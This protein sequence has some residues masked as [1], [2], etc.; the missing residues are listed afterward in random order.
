[1]ENSHPA[2]F[3]RELSA[4]LD[5]E[6]ERRQRLGKSYNG[7]GIFSSRI[8]CGDCGGIY[9]PKVWYST[10]KY[11]R[12]IWRCNRRYAS[13]EETCSTPHLREE[14]I[15][16]AFHVLLKKQAENRPQILEGT[17]A[18][19]EK[20]LDTAKLERKREELDERLEGTFARIRAL[21]EKNAR[22]AMEQDTFLAEHRALSDRCAALTAETEKLDNRISEMRGRKAA[23]DEYLA[24]LEQAEHLPI[25]FSRRL[26]NMTVESLT[27]YEDKRLVFR[28]KDGTVSTYHPS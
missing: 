7:A 21:I 1:M 26:W 10:T 18:A 4:L 14:E 6:R 3:S 24:A 19:I 28:W 5:M 22:E 11:R 25:E 2:I 20:V 17:R 8:V 23:I 12:I 27:V 13:D 16:D 15:V 9:G